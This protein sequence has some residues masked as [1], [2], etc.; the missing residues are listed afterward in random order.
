MAHGVADIVR[1]TRLMEGA[2]S[3]FSAG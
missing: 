3:R 1:V 2:V